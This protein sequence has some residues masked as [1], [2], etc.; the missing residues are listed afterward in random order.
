MSETI[1]PLD[2]LG[3]ARHLGIS[4]STL[5]KLR[6]FGGGPS[7]MKL[8]RSVRYRISDLDVWMSDRVVCSTSDPIHKIA[9]I[10]QGS[11]RRR[12]GEL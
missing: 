11:V 2:T 12:S 5:E 1:T 6:V 9:G 10:G 7:F 3:A 8:G 4:K